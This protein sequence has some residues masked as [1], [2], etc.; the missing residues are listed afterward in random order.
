MQEIE[1][2]IPCHPRCVAMLRHILA[3][4][5]CFSPLRT[6]E[7]ARPLI[8]RIVKSEHVWLDGVMGY[9]AQIAGVG[10]AYP[11]QTAKNALVRQLKRRSARAFSILSESMVCCPAG[12]PFYTPRDARRLEPLQ[13]YAYLFLKR[14]RE[15]EAASLSWLA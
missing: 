11:G 5:A 15:A 7:Q 6:V 8:E 9:E 4:D 2:S 10:D 3:A 1:R 13:D 14:K 12:R